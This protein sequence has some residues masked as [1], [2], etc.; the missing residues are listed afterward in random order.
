M[1]TDVIAATGTSA[2]IRLKSERFDLMA[3]LLGAEGDDSRLAEII[4]VHPRTIKRARG[5]QIG[6]V[7]MAQCVEGFKRHEQTL[8]RYGIKPTLDDLFEVIEVAA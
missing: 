1:D 7:F 2:V 6:E 3:K 5:G 4:G 8:S